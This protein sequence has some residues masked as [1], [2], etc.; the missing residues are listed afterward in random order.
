MTDSRPQIE[1]EIRERLASVDVDSLDNEKVM[2]TILVSMTRME[3]KQD[4][5]QL[6][7]D[8]NTL[9][10]SD[11][12][13]DDKERFDS[14]ERNITTINIEGGKFSGAKGMAVWLV[15]IALALLAIAT[16]IGIA[17]LT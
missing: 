13:K 12:R 4:Y 3:V 16:S 5:F 6:G 17:V 11:H 9:A 15:S 1:R 2:R 10:L 14:L 8:A 7:L